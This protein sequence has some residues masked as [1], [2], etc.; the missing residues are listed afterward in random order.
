MAAYD[1]DGTAY[2]CHMFVPITHG[3]SDAIRELS[4]K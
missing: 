1:V 3:K 4:P 2:P